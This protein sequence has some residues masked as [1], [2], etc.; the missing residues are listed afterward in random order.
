MISLRCDISIVPPE[1]II[2]AETHSFN[3]EIINDSY[4]FQLQSSPHRAVY[5]RSTTGNHISLPAVY[6]KLKLICG[7]YL[8]PTHK[9]T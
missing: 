6:I 1:Y 5:V 4:M 2:R 8:S 3:V 9:G 7:R